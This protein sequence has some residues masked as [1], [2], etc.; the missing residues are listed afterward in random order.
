MRVDLDVAALVARDA[1]ALEEGGV[2]HDADGEDG[3]VRRER[4]AAL[5]RDGERV[6]LVRERSGTVAEQEIDAALDELPL[7]IGH[8]VRIERREDVVCRLEERHGAAHLFQVLRRL[9]ADEAAAD[10]DGAPSLLRE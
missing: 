9:H 2:R 1:A 8:H 3:E 7:E 5:Q 4:P 6:G 10:D